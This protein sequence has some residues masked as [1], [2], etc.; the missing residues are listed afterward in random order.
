VKNAAQANG[1]TGQSSIELFEAII[2]R[3]VSDHPFKYPVI[4]HRLHKKGK[5]GDWAK[6]DLEWSLE[7]SERALIA[8]GSGS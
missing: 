8:K 6:A 4:P 2:C 3:Q 7:K 1:E 5:E